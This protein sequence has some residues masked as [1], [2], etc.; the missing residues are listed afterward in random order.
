MHLS[1][2][3]PCPAPR[4]ASPALTAAAVQQGDA[5]EGLAG[6]GARPGARGRLGPQQPDPPLLCPARQ[7]GQ[8][9]VTLQRVPAQVSTGRQGGL[10]GQW[11]GLGTAGPATTN[12]QKSQTYISL[13]L[14]KLAN[15]PS[16]KAE[17]LLLLMSL[18]ER[19]FDPVGRRPG[20]RRDDKRLSPVH[21]VECHSCLE[22][23]LTTLS[24]LRGSLGARRPAP[25]AGC[26]RRLW[27][28]KPLHVSAGAQG[29]TR[30]R[31][32]SSPAAASHSELP[33]PSR[34]SGERSDGG[35]ESQSQRPWPTTPL[36]RQGGSAPRW[37]GLSP[38]HGFRT[39]KAARGALG[40]GAQLLPAGGTG[41]CP[42][43]QW[44][45]R[46]QTN[47]AGLWRMTPQQSNRDGPG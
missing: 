35:Q 3:P 19:G 11:A 36:A 47:G 20:N 29:R 8:T 41:E 22:G 33:I 12:Q 7:P 27:G 14:N 38:P 42:E 2:E 28:A 17:I 40:P 37:A 5:E 45:H 34:A 6:Q 23:T 18:E 15:I 10:S 32:G 44:G 25:G 4:P 43:T 21:P 13:K 30:A 31:G 46:D 24:A 39:H 9:T 26:G 16:S 1:P